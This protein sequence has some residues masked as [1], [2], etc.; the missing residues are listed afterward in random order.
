MINMNGH[1]LINL[2]TTS[3]PLFLQM[4]PAKELELP[5]LKESNGYLNEARIF[6]SSPNFYAPVYKDLAV[7]IITVWYRS[8]C[9]V[10]ILVTLHDI[11]LSN[12][13]R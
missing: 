10:R 4:Q 9:R 7:E 1:P 11:L 5:Q 8:A 13:Y 12:K 6:R 3:F 2:L